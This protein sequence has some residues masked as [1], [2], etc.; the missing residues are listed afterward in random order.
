M[1]AQASVD[2]QQVILKNIAEGDYTALYPSIILAK[3]ISPETV[4][5]VTSDSY[6]Y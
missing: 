1:Y 2:L 5:K 4:S 6:K 3:N